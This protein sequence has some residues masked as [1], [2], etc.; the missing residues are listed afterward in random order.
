MSVTIYESDDRTL[1]RLLTELLN[2][3]EKAK[4]LKNE[5][6]ELERKKLDLDKKELELMR[7]DLLLK[8]EFLNQE[9]AILEK[10]KK[11]IDEQFEKMIN[12][13]NRTTGLYV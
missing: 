13:E 6:F 4:S 10:R 2:E 11:L 8:K 12:Q 1:F 3:K 5:E 7:K 9:A